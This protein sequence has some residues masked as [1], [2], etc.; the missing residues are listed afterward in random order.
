VVVQAWHWTDL[1]AGI[2]EIGRVLIPGGVVVL[3]DVFPSCRR[4]GP[5]LTMLRR[6]HTVV[7]AELGAV[8]AAHHLAVIGRDHTSWFSLPDVQ[9]IAAR[10]PHLGSANVPT[11]Q[12]PSR[13]AR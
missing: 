13:A 1:A 11:Q 2:A 8:L 10:Q 12:Q 3:A 6:R 7:P 5:A 4:R 9:V